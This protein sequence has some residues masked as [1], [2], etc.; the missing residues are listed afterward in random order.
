MSTDNG[1]QTL[2]SM[3]QAVWYNQWTVKKF[4]SFL[5]GDI[6]EVGCGIGNFTN[7]L[8]KYGNVW[9]IDINENYLKQ[10]MDTDIKIGL[11]DIEKGEYFFKNKKFDTIVCLN[12]LEHI[13]DDKRALQNML[14]LLK[15][16]GHLILLVP[17]YDFLFGEIDKSIGHFRRYDKNKLKSLLKDMGFKIIKSRVINFLGGVGWF[18]SSKL[19]SESKINESKIKV[20]NFIAPFFLSLENLIEPPL[21]T[22]ILIIARK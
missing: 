15:T 3:S 17:A 1:T 9:S 13:K 22:S 6:L 11:G 2:E 19:F 18:L 14:L 16:G 7:F 5:T 20:F 10:F 12:V 8:K 21:G 4:E